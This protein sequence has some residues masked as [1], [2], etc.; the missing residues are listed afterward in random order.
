MPNWN[1]NEVEI[2][3][4]LKEVKKYLVPVSKDEY[5]FNMHQIF[6]EKFDANDLDGSINWEY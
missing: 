4:P 3:A 6:P 2:F 1:S 5:K